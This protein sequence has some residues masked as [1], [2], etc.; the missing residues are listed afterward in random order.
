MCWMWLSAVFDEMNSCVGDLARRLALGDQSQHLDFS[1]SQA[2]RARVVC[3]PDE[4][5]ASELDL[6]P[7][8][9]RGIVEIELLLRRT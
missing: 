2:G 8:V 7:G 1:T 6:L 5:P 4:R 3:L 9:D